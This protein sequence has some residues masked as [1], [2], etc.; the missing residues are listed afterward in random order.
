MKVKKITHYIQVSLFGLVF[1]CTPSYSVT[2]V[3]LMVV[4]SRSTGNLMVDPEAKIVSFV[5]YANR[6]LV[7]T[8]T[9]YEYRLVHT[10]EI[11]W[12]GDDSLGGSQLNSLRLDPAIRQLRNQNGADL[13]AAIV[14]QT[15]GL[16]GIG[17]VLNG[18][19][20]TQKFFRGVEDYGYSATGH[21]CGGNAFAHEVGHTLGLGHSPAQ[22]SSGGLFR[23]GRGWGVD[24]EFV[25][26]M[27]YGS[28]YNVRSSRGFLQIHSNPNLN[29]CLGRPCGKDAS[30]PDGADAKRALDVAA[31]QV[32]AFMPTATPLPGAKIFEDAEDGTTRG[33]AIADNAPSGATI[34]NVYDG[35]AQSRVIELSGAQKQNAYRLGKDSNGGVWG[36]SKLKT[37]EWSMRFSESFTVFVDLQTTGGRRFIRYRPGVNLPTGHGPYVDYGLGYQLTRGNWKTFTRDLEDD[38]H[39]RLPS[40]NILS[41]NG[42]RVRGSGRIDNVKLK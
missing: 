33:W 42:I 8:G 22:G 39:I 15:N 34:T 32:A 13:V 10:E 6:A 4:Y 38:L 1:F 24:T 40:E 2:T 25:T 30:L 17:Y 29:S 7:N 37:L 28:A 31:P 16:C 14:P 26:I 18:D 3:D 21:S 23:T 36:E 20:S 12:T 9:D 35:V 41:V 27:A 11:S 5:E 19:S